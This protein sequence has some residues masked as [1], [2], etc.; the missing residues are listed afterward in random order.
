M[1]RLAFLS[2]LAIVLHSL[3]DMRPRENPKSRP[4]YIRQRREIFHGGET[5]ITGGTTR[6]PSALFTIENLWPCRDKADTTGNLYH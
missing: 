3:F 6:S 1:P 4:L 5:S 2:Q